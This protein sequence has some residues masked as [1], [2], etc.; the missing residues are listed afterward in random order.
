MWLCTFLGSMITIL[1]YSYWRWVGITRCFICD[2]PHISPTASAVLVSRC[3]ILA[4]SGHAKWLQ[5]YW[6]SEVN[7]KHVM[8]WLWPWAVQTYRRWKGAGQFHHSEEYCQSYKMLTHTHTHTHIHAHKHAHILQARH[9]PGWTQHWFG[10]K[11]QV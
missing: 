8:M 7:V 11:K 4:C 2:S 10:K 1:S 3:W 5:F 9:Q 6:F